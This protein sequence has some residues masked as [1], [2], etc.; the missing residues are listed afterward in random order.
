MPVEE[1]PPVD[2]AE[3]ADVPAMDVAP[4]DVDPPRDV[5]PEDDD[6]EDEEEDDEDEEEAVFSSSLLVQPVVAMTNVM[7]NAAA[8][9]QAVFHMCDSPRRSMKWM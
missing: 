7:P 2:D 8:C 3:I 4:E 6:E 1:A 5:A 9:F